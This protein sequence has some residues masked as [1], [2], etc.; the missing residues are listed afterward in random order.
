[1][2]TIQTS[3]ALRVARLDL[4]TTDNTTLYTVPNRYDSIVESII[5]SEDSGNADTITVT[6]TDAASAV[7]NLFKVKAVSANGTVEL[8]SRDLLLTAGDILKVQ[9]ATANRLHVV[10]SITEIPS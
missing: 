7:F 5:I 9:A 2:S 3:S 8:L 4:T 6:I 1:M 10:A